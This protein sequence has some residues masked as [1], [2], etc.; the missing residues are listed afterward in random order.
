LLKKPFAFGIILLFLLSSLIP[1]VSSDNYQEDGNEKTNGGSRT[2]IIDEHFEGTWITSDDP[3]DPIPYEVPVH[4]IYG[5]WD[6]DGL[7]VTGHGGG[8]PG[9]HYI[10]QM[11]NWTGNYNLTYDGDYCAGA[12]WSDLPPDDEQDEWL[13]T[14]EMNLYNVCDLELSFYGI[15][16][17]DSPWD[18]HVY[19]KVSTDGGNNWTI[20]ADLL[21]DPQYEQGNGTG[22]Y[23][24][25]CVNEYQVIL[26][27]SVYD[28]ETSVIIAYH[29]KGA[30]TMMGVNYI[31]AFV[32]TGTVNSPPP[33]SNFEHEPI[34]PNVNETI[35]FTDTSTDIYGDI[36]LWYW[37]FGDGNTSFI[38]NPTHQY[39][40]SGI[41]SA[42]LT[43]TDNDGMTDDTCKS[44]LV[45]YPIMRI[46]NI[47]SGWNFIS[48][49]FNQTVNPNQLILKYNGYYYNWTMSVTDRNPSGSPLVNAFIFGWNRINQLY[50]Y[51]TTM[52][53]G[54]GY[55][56]YSYQPSEIFIQTDSIPDNEY[57]T[58][59][60]Q[61]WNI[62]SI[63]Y[64]ISLNKTNIKVGY[65]DVDY[66]W[67]DAVSN[68]IIDDFVFGWDR[69][70]QSYT[71]ADMFMPGY[72]YWLYAY[73]PCTLKRGH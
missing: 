33:I 56:L 62:I 29:L 15:W 36:V 14:P 11:A 52:K 4:P 58:N 54:Y 2:L 61:N 16:H 17:W 3:D 55:W 24:G 42:T 45:N 68:D 43:V 59:V 10:S 66:T 65:M 13:K 69:N 9:I 39:N 23:Y 41:Y 18:D 22:D 48:L 8:H 19:I 25:W 60:E 64:N 35:V 57:I 20:H 5:E 73:Q 28:Y 47:T 7:C 46:T 32:L 30:P 6:I 71:F 26:N 67:D 12:W 34:L 37:D 44:I 31:D 21:Q 27:L 72:A 63:P 50:L 70:T 1:M 49:P 40:K 38:Q 51:E 53:S